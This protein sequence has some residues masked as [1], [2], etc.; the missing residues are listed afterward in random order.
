VTFFQEPCGKMSGERR[1]SRNDRGYRSV[2]HHAA[3][4]SNRV[5]CPRELLVVRQDPLNYPR[6]PGK[7]ARRMR[8]QPFRHMP[9]IPEFRLQP[10]TA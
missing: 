5:N 4:S 2:G 3:R 9:Y 8:S 6:K 1:R 10:G 7:P